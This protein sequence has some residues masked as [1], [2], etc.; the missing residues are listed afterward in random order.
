M[1]EGAAKYAR[2]R[3]VL[4]RISRDGHSSYLYGTIHIGRF[5]WLFPGPVLGEAL[6]SSEVLALELDP[7]DPEMQARMQAALNGLGAAPTGEAKAGSDFAARVARQTQLACLPA[8]ALSPLSPFLQAMALSLLAGRSAGLDAGYAQ[9]YLLAG[10]ARGAQR[11]IVSLETPESQA[12]ALLPDKP[13][14]VQ[15]M[16]EDMLLQLEQGTSLA[17][18]KRLADIWE[19]GDLALLETYEQWCQCVQTDADREYFR[20]LNDDRN[21]HIAEGINK[22]H[23]EGN[24]VFAAIGALHMS[25]ANALPKLM[26]NL[27]Y[28][29]ERVRFAP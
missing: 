28:S 18:M 1:R 16:A 13:E 14:R 9:E 15:Q 17:M 26:A 5:E 4:W 12:A 24:K 8:A 20:A 23:A 2:D 6:R 21:Q 10:M 11:R 22:L 29:V 3:G 27:G 25:G 19:N 7:T